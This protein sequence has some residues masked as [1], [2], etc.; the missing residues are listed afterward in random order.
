MR[1]III[2]IPILLLV[3]SCTE[4]ET[5]D[6]KVSEIK[7]SGTVYTNDF[8][9]ILNGI[10]VELK[11]NE[12]LK[13]TTDINGNYNFSI[14]SSGEYVLSIYDSSYIQFDTTL[15]ISN[16][17]SLRIN[18][19][20]KASS[21][22]M[23]PPNLDFGNV[24]LGSNST[25]PAIVDNPGT[26]YLVITNI[27][28]SDAH[29]TFAPN[30]FPITI[31]P[32]NNKVIYVTYTPTTLGLTTADL[33]FTHN[34]S[35]SPTVYPVQGTGVEANDYFPLSIGNWWSYS[36]DYHPCS[37]DWISGRQIGTLTWKVLST[38]SDSIY[39]I[40][41]T[42]DGIELNYV[43]IYEIDT[44]IIQT[45]QIIEFNSDENGMIT[46]DSQNHFGDVLHIKLSRYFQSNLNSI[47]LNYR[48]NYYSELDSNIIKLN[49]YECGYKVKLLKEIG[50]NTIII[51]PWSNCSPVGQFDLIDYEIQ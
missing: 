25:L 49:S 41:E 31:T 45:Q 42:I 47:V 5:V 39:Y 44:S 11:G 50:I 12:T 18:L 43:P 23:S 40:E 15:F 16:D 32:G 28:S 6:P 24:V 2:I 33:T 8:T 17:I 14:K 10:E 26:S 20:Y 4:N 38:Q 27:V 9:N 3:I 51:K 46:I 19:T 22:T 37:S 34:A 29:F 48:F 30:T 36:Y 13:D 1:N 21:I 7:I 35:G